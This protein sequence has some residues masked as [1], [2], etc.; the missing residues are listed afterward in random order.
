ME[1]VATD[2]LDNWTGPADV[3]RP[4]GRALG[5]EHM[6]LRLY[7]LEPGEST[8][9]GYHAHENQEEVFY[10]LDGVLTFE[11]EGGDI[12]V[13]AGEAVRF[14][15]GEFQQS[16]NAGDGRTRV[17]GMG[18]PADPGELTLLRVRPSPALRLCWNSPGPKRTASPALTS[19]SPPSISKASV[20]SRT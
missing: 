18:A 19:T 7:E 11:T 5:T 6:G 16:R 20:P 17:L 12:E 13:G 1:H 9:F 14:G 3:K 4:V 15:P 10:I 8:A 2:D